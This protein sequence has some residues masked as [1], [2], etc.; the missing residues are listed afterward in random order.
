MRDTGW[1]RGRSARVANDFVRR[2]W[3]PES[4][5]CIAS[6]IQIGSFREEDPVARAACPFDLRARTILLGVSGSR[7]QGLAGPDSDVD[8][9]GVAVAPPGVLLGFHQ[10][11]EQADQAQDMSVFAGLLTAGERCVAER[12]KLEGSVYALAKF[13]RL[14][15]DCNPNMVELLFCRD[16]ELRLCTEVG[17]R[18]REAAPL[19]LSQKAGQT[20]TGYAMGQLKRIEGHRHWLLRPPAG[21]PTRAQFSLPERTLLPREQLLAADAEVRKKLDGW[22]VDWGPLP[23]SEIQRLEDRLAGF[24]SELLRAGESRWHL[25]ARAVGLDDNLVEVMDRERRYRAAQRN[26][27]QYRTWKRQRNP[28]RAALE[29]EFGYD[30]KHGA[31]LIRLLRMGLEIVQTGEVHVWRGGIDGEEL[32]AIRR[33]AWSYEALVS[34]ARAQTQ[35]LRSLLEEGRSPLPAKPDLDGLNRLVVQLTTCML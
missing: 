31:H 30:T 3:A 33:G 17:T 16:T 1:V 2:G 22:S 26:W 8:L 24:M 27:E 32:K 12:T 23:G 4:M 35:Q 25:A 19:F 13:V 7:A 29:A 34:Q 14:C 11:F 28:A 18:L 10:R 15:A 5:G 21:P 6:R 20:F 9:R